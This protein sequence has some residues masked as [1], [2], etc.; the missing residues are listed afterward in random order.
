ME[1]E[2]MRN[3]F[4]KELYY[5]I[6]GMCWLRFK[7]Y[8]K[9]KNYDDFVGAKQCPNCKRITLEPTTEFIKDCKFTNKKI[10]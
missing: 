8:W 2:D 3:T 1:D 4:D 6:C 5:A 7:F 9:P 10:K